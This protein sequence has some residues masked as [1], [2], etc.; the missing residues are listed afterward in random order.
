MLLDTTVR[1]VQKANKPTSRAPE[2]RT[3]TKNSMKP[4][5]GRTGDSQQKDLHKNTKRVRTRVRSRGN[6]AAY[7]KPVPRKK[8]A[9]PRKPRQL[10]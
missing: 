1:G 5:A 6:K 9:A 4:R 10:T 2:V 3:S 7:K 8:A